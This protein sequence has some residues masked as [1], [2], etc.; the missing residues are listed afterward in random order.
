M[1]IYRVNSVTRRHDEATGANAER[2]ERN[3]ERNGENTLQ[4]TDIDIKQMSGCNA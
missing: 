1:S 4:H 2:A 3:N